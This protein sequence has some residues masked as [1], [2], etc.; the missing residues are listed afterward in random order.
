MI[1]KVLTMAIA[2]LMAT[3]LF[4]GCGSKKEEAPGVDND[5]VVEL[6][7]WGDWTGDGE[8]RMDKMIEDFNKEYPNIHIDYVPQP[9]LT[10]K[11]L[12]SVAAG[13]SPDI[14]FWDRYLTATYAEKGFLLPIDDLVKKNNVNLDVFYES[15]VEEF[16]YKDKLYGL[17][18]IS[19]TRTLAYNVK[20]FEEAG[21]KAPETWDDIMEAGKALSKVNSSGKNDRWL[22]SSDN[23]FSLL[24]FM[25]QAGGHPTDEDG[26]LTYNTDA[27][28][29]AIGFWDQLIKDKSVVF[30]K[31]TLEDFVQEKSA[32]MICD[33]GAIKNIAKSATEGFEYKFIEM[34][35][36]KNGDKGTLLGG[37][38]LAIPKASKNQDAAFTF[39]NW[40]ASNSE[41]AGKFVDMGSSLP[42]H[43]DLAD[44]GKVLDNPEAF[45]P[46]I[47]SLEYAKA[48]PSVT[49]W[50]K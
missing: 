19:D 50:E 27:A 1:K 45:T 7:F 24:P 15:G 2:T 5:E 46:F 33:P 12:T 35:M 26:N 18:V 48:R 36:G 13:T 43:K 29:A 3:S 41:Q 49:W 23:T 10:D 9:E 30:S 8:K 47:N 21:L 14:L 32:M 25:L 16:T 4:V 42:S 39:V 31:T 34:P 6:Q 38:G 17:P 28:K 11:L 22:F 37:F 20:M 40:W 44:K